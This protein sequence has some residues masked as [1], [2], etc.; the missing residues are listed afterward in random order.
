M[1]KII[2]FLTSP[3]FTV[4]RVLALVSCSMWLMMLFLLNVAALAQS[5]TSP[6]RS[7]PTFSDLATQEYRQNIENEHRF[8]VLET[9]VKNIDERTS[10]IQTC[11][12]ALVVGM[13]GLVGERGISIVK[14]RKHK[15]TNNL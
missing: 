1:N 7:S 10:F 2:Q 5:M 13:S 14:E 6:P 8:S 4:I 9:V 3:Q 11:M 15:G 12:W